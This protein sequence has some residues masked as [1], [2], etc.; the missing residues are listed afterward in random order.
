MV[1]WLDL[2]PI[3]VLVGQELKVRKERQGGWATTACMV[4]GTTGRTWW[5]KGSGSG[6]GG[7]GDGNGLNC[8]AK[9]IPTITGFQNLPL[10]PWQLVMYHLKAQ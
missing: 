3:R 1:H 10:H 4:W 8:K 9:A 5:G 6:R 2:S 7:E